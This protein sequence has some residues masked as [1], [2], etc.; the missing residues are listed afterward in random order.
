MHIKTDP[1]V[2]FDMRAESIRELLL[3][4]SWC[5][6]SPDHLVSLLRVR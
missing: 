2:Q 3:D 5:S 4:G 1:G 6:R